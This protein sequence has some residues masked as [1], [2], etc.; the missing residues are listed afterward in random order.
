MPQYRHTV[1]QRVFG[2][3]SHR[4]R[5][6]HAWIVSR[7]GARLGHD[8]RAKFDAAIP[9][10]LASLKHA[11]AQVR[12]ARNGQG[13]VDGFLPLLRSCFRVPADAAGAVLQR[14]L[15]SVLAVLQATRAGLKTVDLQIVD[16]NPNR[17]Q[18]AQGYVR[19][20][21]SELFRTDDP[22]RPAAFAGRIHMHFAQALRKRDALNALV[23]IHEATHR[24]AGTRDWSYLPSESGLVELE[25]ELIDAGGRDA[26]RGGFFG[27]TNE[28]AL[29]NADSHAGFVM[30]MAGAG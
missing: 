5:V 4:V 11:I 8:I 22:A 16:E 3:P 23:L 10:A 13:T 1:T 26:L 27:M 25:A 21:F 14:N 19:M 2:Q 12:L 24:F 29:N 17:G 30:M 15:L 20:A 6:R 7:P 18:G 28:Q 9:V